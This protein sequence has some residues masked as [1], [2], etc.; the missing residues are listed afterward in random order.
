MI[1]IR[2]VLILLGLIVIQWGCVRQEER[3]NDCRWT[4]GQPSAHLDLQADLELAEELAIR[5]METNA[6]PRDQA[7]AAQAKNRCMGILLDE[8]G[9]KHGLSAQEAFRHFG[10]R[11]FLADA[12]MSLPFLMAY[13]LAARFAACCIL[14]RYS[15]DDG[16][17]TAI[18]VVVL[19]SIAFALAGL[20][21]GQQWSALAESIRVGT[22]HLSNRVFRLPLYKHPI[23][24]FFSFA[25]IFLIVAIACHWWG[26][27]T[28]PT[29]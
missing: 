12:L 19:A 8:I 20:L 15:P 6:G 24:S 4:S 29:C 23:E 21:L 11:S 17:L 16:T 2:S 26:R 28:R 7:I 14:S 1:P 18:I 27:N 10:K 9:K 3:N 22:T 5:F 25:S 13:C